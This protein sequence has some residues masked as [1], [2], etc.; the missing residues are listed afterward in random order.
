MIESH[1]S[2]RE[3]KARC[4]NPGIPTSTIIDPTAANI[5]TAIRKVAGW[6]T[7]HPAAFRKLQDKSSAAMTRLGMPTAPATS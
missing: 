4:C 5:P 3:R 2:N 1:N 6:I 7:C